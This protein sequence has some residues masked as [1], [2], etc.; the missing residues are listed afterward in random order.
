MK[1][2]QVVLDSKLLR[3]TDG[4]AKRARINR[5]A[6]IRQALREHLRALRIRE[7]EARDR[8]GYAKLPES[9]KSFAAWERVASWPED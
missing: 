6:L 1:T 9:P 7:L 4:A 8:Q 5:S 2:I 3:A